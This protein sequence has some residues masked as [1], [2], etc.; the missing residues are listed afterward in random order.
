VEALVEPCTADDYGGRGAGGAA[1]S[2]A[3]SDGCCRADCA[4]EMRRISTHCLKLVYQLVCTDPLVSSFAPG[5]ANAFARCAGAR[6]ECRSADL[7]SM[8]GLAAAE[9]AA[10]MANAAAWGATSAAA[11]G[12]AALSGLFVPERVV[13]RWEGAGAL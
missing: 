3:T 7:T 5:I 2:L 4:A 6:L 10:D 1:T 11:R 8:V 9:A 13:A 12:A